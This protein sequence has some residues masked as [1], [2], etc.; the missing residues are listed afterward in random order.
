M[1]SF[2]SSELIDRLLIPGGNMGELIRRKDW[3]K[4][5][6]GARE[7]WPQSLRTLTE[8]LLGQ[9][10]A[11]VLLWGPEL[12][13]IYNDKYREIAGE[14]HPMALGIPTRECWPEAWHINGPIYKKVVEGGES[15]QLLDALI[16]LTR[17]GV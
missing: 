9:P 8:M 3:S 15:V 7:A 11:M 1:N 2:A 17:N 12:V 16:P 5:P 13:Q 4:T 6:L 10:V 14:K